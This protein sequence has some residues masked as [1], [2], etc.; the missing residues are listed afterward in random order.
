M[1]ENLSE[2][3]YLLRSPNNAQRLLE[4]IERSKA[5]DTQQFA[6]KTT[7]QAIA[8]LKQELDAAEV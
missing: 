5:R 7:E 1:T 3:A 2:T 8:D 4:A 6:Y